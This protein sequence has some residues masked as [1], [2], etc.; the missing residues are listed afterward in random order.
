MKCDGATEPVQ[1][2][3]RLGSG[4]VPGVLPDFLFL[5]SAADL[6]LGTDWVRELESHVCVGGILWPG[7]AA[8]VPALG[9]P[10]RSVFSGPSTSWRTD[11]NTPGLSCLLWIRAVDSSS[12]ETPGSTPLL[13]VTRDALGR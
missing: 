8:T 13:Q 4:A 9:S 6:I 11:C 7:M 2:A 12:G 5:A 3:W 1:T 10:S